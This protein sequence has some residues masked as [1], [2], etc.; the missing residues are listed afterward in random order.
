[1]YRVILV[2]TY[3]NI[4]EMRQNINVNILLSWMPSFRRF[5]M[6]NATIGRTLKFRILKIFFLTP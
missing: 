2:K 3:M 5:I 4:K 1:M 6:R